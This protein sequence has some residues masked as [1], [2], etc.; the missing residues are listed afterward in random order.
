MP[1]L[2][3]KML[4]K[5]VKASR[6]RIGDRYIG[7]GSPCFIIAEAGVNHNGDVEIAKKLIVEAKQAEADAVKFQMFRAEDVA[8]RSAEKAEYQ[9][10]STGKEESQYEMIKKLELSEDSFKEL[11]RYAKSKGIL[12]LSSP[13]DDHSV[14]LLSELNVLAFKVASGEITNLPLLSHIAEKKK[15]IILST[16]M[17]TLGEIEEA[18]RL[19]RRHSLDEIALLHCVANYPARIEDL[20]LR[21]I[22]TLKQAFGI[23]VGFSDHTLGIMASVLAVALGAC[24]IEKHFTLDRNLQGPDHKASL[25]PAELREMIRGIRDAEKA[26]G[27]GVKKISKDEEEIKKVGRRSIVARTTIRKGEKIT[28]E[29]LAIKRPATGIEP[30]YVDAIT[31]RVTKKQIEEDEPLQWEYFS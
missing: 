1:H 29:M 25:E 10:Q 30:K 24:I 20:N 11:A 3:K 9:K 23:P 19:I 17:A 7:D 13:F 28:R 14:D 15:P 31:G 12:F 6:I 2:A 4:M 26:L 21:V 5:M 27:D 18:L 8:T 16:G 22:Q